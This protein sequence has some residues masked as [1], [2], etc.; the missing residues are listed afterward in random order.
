MKKKFLRIVS[1]ILIL[2]FTTGLSFGAFFLYKIYRLEKKITVSET[3]HSFLDAF[4]PLTDENFS[5]LKGISDGRINVLLLGLPGKGKP[6]QN[7]TDTIMVASINTKTHQ[8]ALLSL[9]RDLY[10]EIPEEKVKLKINSAYQYAINNS[11]DKN[12][13]ESAA[14]KVTGIINNITNLDIHYWAVLNFDG[15]TEAID[16]VGGINITNERDLYDPRYPGP[17]YSYETFELK[18]GFHHL[19]GKTALKYA[20]E[21]HNDPEGDFGRAKRQ[22]QVMQAAKNK[23]FSTGT[24][25][26]VFSINELLNVLG[27]NMLTNIAPS[28]WEG[29]LALI[30]KLDTDNINTV[31]VDAWKKDS[32]LKVSHV[33][34][35]SSRAF[36]LVPRIGNYSEI[37]EL[38]AQVFDLNLIKKR[39]EEI[40]K[41]ETKIAIINQS[42]V[43]NMTE[44]I[45]KLLVEN[46][47]YKNVTVLNRKDREIIDATTAYDLTNGQKPF[48][49]DEL[50]KKLPSNVSYDFSAKEKELL[51]E[52]ETDIVVLVGKDLID[53]YD[54]EEISQEEFEKASEE[55]DFNNYI[56]DN[57]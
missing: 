12:K 51:D 33:Y 13:T 44:K 14:K 2:S 54:K 25:L 11:D 50:A 45:N 57:M 1:W 42:G 3:N 47:G 34:F 36:V 40:L 27:D 49:L 53:T 17:N 29:F 23:I 8:V 37:Q 5:N 46:F 4:K 39:R 19:D 30:K 28:E 15:F 10:V 43:P 55:E 22:Q 48:T 7:L 35:G 41:E 20:R 24:M 26:N 31:V 38:S 18:K 32:L 56:K 16:A 9:P 52:K 21:R 6:G